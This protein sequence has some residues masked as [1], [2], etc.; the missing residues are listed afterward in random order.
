MQAGHPDIVFVK[1]GFEFILGAVDGVDVELKDIYRR[2]RLWR[3]T[4][5]TLLRTGMRMDVA[6]E[7]DEEQSVEMPV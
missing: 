6:G 1:V 3:R 4:I 2:L 5:V 7:E